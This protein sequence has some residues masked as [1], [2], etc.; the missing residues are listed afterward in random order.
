MGK[1]ASMGLSVMGMDVSDLFDLLAETE[2]TDLLAIKNKQEQFV[3]FMKNEMG[4]EF[5]VEEPDDQPDAA[6]GVVIEDIKES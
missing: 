3:E 5:K 4:D 2:E 1:M 6:A